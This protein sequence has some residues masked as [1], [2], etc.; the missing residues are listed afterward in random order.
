MR[1]PN[2]SLGIS[3]ILSYRECPRRFA[4]QMRRHVEGSDPP[5]DVHPD[6]MYGKAIHDCIS[7]IEDEMIP[8]DEA[9]DRAVRAYP[10]WLDPD[11]I[12][13][14]RKDLETYHERDERGVILV[15]NETEVRIPLLEH[16]YRCDI[17]SGRGRV[18]GTDGPIVCID[19]DGKGVERE[20]TTIHFR[21]RIDR[22]YKL[23]SNPS[24]F[25]HRD[26]KSSKHR[27]SA[28]EVHKDL[29]LWSYNWAIYRQWPECVALTQFY[30]QLQFGDQ[31]PTRKSAEQRELIEDWLKKQVKAVLNDYSLEPDTNQWCPWCSILESCTEVR[32]LGEWAKTRIT[33]I[34]GPDGKLP[35]GGVAPGDLD[36]YVRDRELL[37]R[38][39]KMIDVLDKSVMAVIKDLPPARR[40]ELGYEK[41]SG[42]SKD[43]FPPRA[44]RSIHEIVGDD[45]YS[46]VTVTKTRIG[47]FVTDKDLKKRILDMASKTAGGITVRKKKD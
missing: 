22:L 13:R 26:Y 20:P 31:P 7:W 41:A 6:T 43:E 25:I 23:A 9:I 14:L 47:D 17:C 40:A 29:Q 46:L 30:D 10:K 27:K 16:R 36:E 11:D 28:S 1:L 12:D 39:G 34:A 32:R 3:D 21:G 8:D 33:E 18:A 44:L 45:F 4:F 38:T 35:E 37:V 15:A 24:I 2:D 5:E 19:C 42:R